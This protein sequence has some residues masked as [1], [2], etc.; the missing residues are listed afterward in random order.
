MKNKQQLDWTRPIRTRGGNSVRIYDVFD[1]R[2][3]N[4]SYYEDT[5][6]IWYPCQWSPDGMYGDRESA[7]DLVNTGRINLGKRS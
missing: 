6:D 3:T 4:G 5:E 2:Y 1:G 7:L